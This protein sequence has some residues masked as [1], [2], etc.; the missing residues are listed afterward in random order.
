MKQEARNRE[1]KHHQEVSMV[2]NDRRDQPRVKKIQRYRVSDVV[3]RSYLINDGASA[4]NVNGKGWASEKVGKLCLLSRLLL[5]DFT[6][7]HRCYSLF[8]KL[9]CVITDMRKP[10][11]PN[12]HSSINDRVA[13]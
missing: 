6:Y 9:F 8:T 13:D 10:Y 11:K 2:K 7:F 3:E 1:I 5:F 12:G 4:G